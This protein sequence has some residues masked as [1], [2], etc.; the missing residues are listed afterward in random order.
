M[1][2]KLSILTLAR[3]PLFP[4]SHQIDVIEDQ[5]FVSLT[6]LTT[7]DL[8]HNGVVA[9][10]GQSLS[11]LNEYKQFVIT[12]YFLSFF[13][14]NKDYYCHKLSGKKYKKIREKKLLLLDNIGKSRHIVPVISYENNVH[15]LMFLHVITFLV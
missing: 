14:L 9:I 10:S 6:S 4:C 7:L 15:I 8:S 5:S 3:F 1:L 12:F 2:L 13:F 11:H